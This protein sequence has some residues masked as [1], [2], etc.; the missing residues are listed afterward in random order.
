MTTT[1]P[2]LILVTGASGA[3]LSTAL[4]ILE[5]VG[6]MVVDNLPL[7]MIDTLVALE[8]E[9]GGRSLAIG[10]DVRT[11]GFSPEAVE[12]LVRNL[13]RKFG[14]QFTGVF[15][16]AS[17]D[18]LWR[19]FNATRRQHPL[20]HIGSLEEAISADLERMDQ[21][22]PMADIQID[23]SGAKPSDLRRVLLSKLGMDEEF[24]VQVRLLSFSYRRRLPDHSDL[25]IDM[26]FASN[27]HWVADLRQHDGRDP[28]VIAY[29]EKDEVALG[30]IDS[31]KG[32]LVQMLPRM[33]LEGR[34]IV[35]VA[36]GCTGGKHRSVWATE[37]VGHWLREQGYSVKVAHRE[38]EIE[39]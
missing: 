27:P 3:G 25:V 8:V 34:P 2:R 36:F 17:R 1:S 28:R 20:Q 6:V 12:T 19:R 35:T 32:M 29:L 5:D 31:V 37:T 22:M 16:S 23:T 26:R 11:T 30:V 15:V 33:S 39:S 10:L 14:A 21:V 7:A 13:R 38:I 4:N 24:Q 18:D 9:T